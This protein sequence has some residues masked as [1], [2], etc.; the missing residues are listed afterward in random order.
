MSKAYRESTGLVN[1]LQVTGSRKAGLDGGFLDIYAGTVPADADA[2][3]GG[4]TLLSTLTLGGDDV[5]GLT[6]DATATD[7]VIKKPDA[8]VWRDPTPPATGTASFFRWRQTGDTGALS[9][10]DRRIQGTVGTI[11]CDLNLNSTTITTG[12]AF[13]INTF[14]IRQPKGFGL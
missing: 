9:T 13:E 2:S 3:I 12:V 11:G 14:T 6:I 5:T 4:A 8:A 7:G 1:Y 10:T